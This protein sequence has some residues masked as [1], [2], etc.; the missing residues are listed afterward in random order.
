MKQELC[1]H[2]FFYSL[3]VKVTIGFTKKKYGFKKQYLCVCVCVNLKLFI[4]ILHT[5]LS[6]NTKTKAFKQKYW[7]PHLSLLTPLLLL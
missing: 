2:N 4:V 6:V 1:V 3:P 5:F 7:N